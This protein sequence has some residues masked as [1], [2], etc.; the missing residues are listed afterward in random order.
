MHKCNKCLKQIKLPNNTY[1]G[2]RTLASNNPVTSMHKCKRCLET[3]SNINY[4]GDN[5]LCPTCL[6]RI[7]LFLS[8][9][10]I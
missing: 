5:P 10:F 8:I 4:T 2:T 9:N 6:K 1:K 7:K 3:F